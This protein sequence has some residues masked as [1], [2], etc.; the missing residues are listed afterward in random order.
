MEP[1]YDDRTASTHIHCRRVPRTSFPVTV[2]ACASSTKETGWGEVDRR[3]L[4]MEYR[5][6][7]LLTVEEV[8]PDQPA[9]VITAYPTIKFNYKR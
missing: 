7:V 1:P 6:L 2:R 4:L 3:I 8:V 9:E 5:T